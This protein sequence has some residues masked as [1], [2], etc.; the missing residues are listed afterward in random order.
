MAILTL[1]ALNLLFV[2]CQDT[3]RSFKVGRLAR[4]GVQR[5]GSVRFGAGDDFEEAFARP[6]NQLGQPPAEP[7]ALDAHVLGGGSLCS[8]IPRQS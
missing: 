1:P 2:C 5:G 8:S 6:L 7:Y 3:E 4:P